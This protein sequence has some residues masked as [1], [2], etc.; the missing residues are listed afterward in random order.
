MA[1][2]IFIYWNWECGYDIAED[3]KL[4]LWCLFIIFIKDS[5]LRELGMLIFLEFRILIWWNGGGQLNGFENAGLL[6]M[7]MII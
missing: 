5:D 2:R 1:V 7:R 3:S 6:Q 4:F